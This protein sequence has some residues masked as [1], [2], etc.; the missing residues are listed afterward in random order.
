MRCEVTYEELA[1]LDAGEV[2]DARGREL[3]A[4]VAACAEC[5]RRLDDL[6][7]A[8]SAMAGLRREEPSAGAVLETRRAL[9]R[10]VRGRSEPDI[11]TLEEAAEYLRVDSR[12]LNVEEW[13]LPVFEIGGRLRVRRARLVEWVENRERAYARGSAA[14]EVARIVG[15][16]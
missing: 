14:S 3:A 5:R 6:R 12:E 8:D 9:S 2:D 16:D 7:E 11:M 10:E 4:H 15:A 1:L 13:G